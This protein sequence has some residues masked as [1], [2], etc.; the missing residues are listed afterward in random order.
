MDEKQF[1]EATAEAARGGDTDAARDVL[2]AFVTAVDVYSGQTWD[3]PLH[4][5]QARYI[6]DAFQRILDDPEPKGKGFYERTTDALGLKGKPGRPR[7]A[8]TFDDQALAAMFHFLVAEGEA[9]AKAK[10]LVMDEIGCDEITM[11]RA[12][13][14]CGWPDELTKDRGLPTD[15]GFL[16]SQFT[17]RGENGSTL[18]ANEQRYQ[19]ALQAIRKRIRH[20]AHRRG[21]KR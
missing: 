11:R 15:R 18:P 14:N 9:E 16:K 1:I 10:N 20:D 6:A 3:G 2:Q 12:I 19:K 7:G 21:G 8:V 4:Y 13:R 5:A 17:L